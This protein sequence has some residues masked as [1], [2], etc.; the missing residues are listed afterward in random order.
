MLQKKEGDFGQNSPFL[1]N[2]IFPQENTIPRSKIF[3]TKNV[4]KKREGFS[5]EF[6][7]PSSKIFP[8]RKVQFLVK[9]Y[10]L[11]KK[12]QKKRRDFLQNSLIFIKNILIKFQFLDPKYF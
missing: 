10:F 2:K 4:A 3:P 1:H 5:T 6:T 9:K 11:Q 8:D 12:L 7:I